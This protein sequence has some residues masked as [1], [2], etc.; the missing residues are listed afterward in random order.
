MKAE[1]FAASLAVGREKAGFDS[2]P[3]ALLDAPVF[4]MMSDLKEVTADLR[5]RI[6]FEKEFFLAFTID[7]E[8]GLDA[9]KTAPGKFIPEADGKG[10]ESLEPDAGFANIGEQCC[11]LSEEPKFAAKEFFGQAG[12]K[13]AE[14]R[15]QLLDVL[16]GI[17][18]G[19]GTLSFVES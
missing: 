12:P 14:E 5:R 4:D 10:I 1:V 3:F 17:M 13:E 19:L 16:A 11:G 15:S 18:N 2:G 9:G 8:R 6:L 7:L